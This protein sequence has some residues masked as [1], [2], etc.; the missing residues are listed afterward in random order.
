MD[1]H[2]QEAV[3]SIPCFDLDE[4]GIGTCVHILEYDRESEEVIEIFGIIEDVKLD[5]LTINYFDH[6]NGMNIKKR[7]YIKIKAVLDH[8]C[9]IEK[10]QPSKKKYRTSFLKK[11]NEEKKLSFPHLSL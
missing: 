10:L 7:K 9:S 6:Q 5:Q 3:K 4:L 1:P 2:H 8:K 11:H